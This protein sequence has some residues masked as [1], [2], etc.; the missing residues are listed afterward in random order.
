MRV[1]TMG[2]LS[3]MPLPGCPRPAPLGGCTSSSHPGKVVFVGLTNFGLSGPGL[4]EILGTQ[5]TF[6]FKP[7]QNAGVLKAIFRTVARFPLDFFILCNPRCGLVSSEFVPAYC[8]GAAR[9]F[10]GW[11]TLHAVLLP[12][13]SPGLQIITLLYIATLLLTIIKATGCCINNFFLGGGRLN[14]AHC[15]L[16]PWL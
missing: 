1:G 2:M 15:P 5:R 14:W 8:H 7:P 16:H 10:F 12:K 3:G 9:C 13:V 6:A 11:V 4:S